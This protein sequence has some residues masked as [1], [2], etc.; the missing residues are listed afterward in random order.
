M[1]KVALFYIHLG[2][3]IMIKRK[4]S[5]ML[6]KLCKNLDYI[7]IKYK[8]KTINKNNLNIRRGDIKDLNLII[9]KILTV[10]NL[11]IKIKE[12]NQQKV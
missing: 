3:W 5:F 6:N 1:I 12:Y 10:I 9:K 4:I 11:L 7:G 2:I 8:I